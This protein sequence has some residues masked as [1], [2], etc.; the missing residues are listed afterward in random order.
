[1]YLWHLDKPP[2]SLYWQINDTFAADKH[3]ARRNPLGIEFLP[4]KQSAREMIFP[5]WFAV[6]MGNGPKSSHPS[7]PPYIIA[8]L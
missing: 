5:S 2:Y 7:A 8:I 4:R 3:L 6:E 1:M